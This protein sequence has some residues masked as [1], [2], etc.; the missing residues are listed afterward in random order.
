MLTKD[1]LH[2]SDTF[3]VIENIGRIDFSCLAEGNQARRRFTVSVVHRAAGRYTVTNNEKCADAAGEWSYEPEPSRHENPSRSEQ[4]W[5]A[6]H[7]FDLATA[8]ALAI[9]L[10]TVVILDYEGDVV[11]NR[12]SSQRLPVRSTVVGGLAVVDDLDSV[13]DVFRESLRHAAQVGH[14]DWADPF[15]VEPV[16]RWI[17]DGELL[18]WAEDGRIVGVARA[19]TVPS[20]SVWGDPGDVALYVGKLATADSVRGEQFCATH[21]LP[22]LLDYAV[23]AGA[24]SVRIDSLADNPGLTQLYSGAGFTQRG[25][26]TFQSVLNPGRAVTV[27]RWEWLI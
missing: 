18:R 27:I 5:D 9:K 12:D 19:T 16:Q 6:D 26:A 2:E 3:P 7:R 24:T 8:R 22:Y 15:P 1:G 13:M 20:P 25:E 11:T 10:A 21:M 17:S 4:C 23:A 14:I